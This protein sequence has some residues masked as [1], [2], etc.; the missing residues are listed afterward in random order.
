MEQHQMDDGNVKTRQGA[1]PLPLRRVR[2]T[3]AFWAPRRELVRAHTLPQQEQQ[4]RTAGG[5]FD[6]LKLTWKPGDD[7][8]PHI[9]WE[10]D[11]AKWI[12]AASYS[13]AKTPDPEL[14]RSVDEA[15]ELL[16]GAQQADGYLNVYFT[17]VRPGERFTDLR[18]THELY[19]AGHLIEAAVAHHDATGKITLLEI[20]RRYADLIDHEFGPGGSAEG[21]Y[22]GHQE[23][24]LALIRLARAT[25]DDRYK[26]LSLRLL[27][28]RG[29]RPFFFE[30]E[31]EKRGTVG[32][33]GQLFPVRVEDAERFREY[34]QSHLPVREQ[35]EA[36]GHSVRAMYMY[37][38]MTDFAAELDDEGLREA[39]LRLWESATG[40]KMYVTGGIGSDPSIEGFGQDYDLTIENAY[41]ETC[42][43]VG[44]VFWAQRM[45]LMTQDG[46]YADVMERALYNGVLAGASRDGTEYFYGNPMQ[47]DGT[48]ERN[49]WFGVACCPPNF[50]RLVE[51]LEYYAY[52]QT[53]ETAIINLYMSG[54]A[55][56][57]LADGEAQISVSTRYPWEGS[58]Q[59]TIDSAD[60]ESFEIALRVPGWV[61]GYQVLINDERTELLAE[62]GYVRVHR[63][64]QQGD[65]FTLTFPIEP[66]RVWA[67]PEVGAAAGRV[68]LE[69]GPIVYCLEGVDNGGHVDR[70]SLPRTA[71][72]ASEWNEELDAVTIETVGELEQTLGAELYANEPPLRTSSVIK[73]VPYYAWANR[74]KSTME[75]WIRESH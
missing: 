55:H 16:A 26:N 29:T 54:S 72:L 2:I 73:A 69:R 32:Y 41:A 53:D 27:N 37:A 52:G 48:I 49:K 6:S 46:Q 21:G 40:R 7:K 4:L 56:F 61:D 17:A 57:A 10:S 1:R 63:T 51:S 43:A 66:R 68:A 24:E 45:A 34:N 28:A 50:A 59:L 14:E 30:K 58:V 25:G 65:T 19:C 62:C 47:S 22:D 20:A 38:A 3:D 75:V 70:I 74:G 18:D 13:L 64:W 5:Q 11:V 23:I 67:R 15:I 36:V 39:T 31:A 33:F 12:E 35:S 8:E 44:L 60:P 71:P 42:A 9:F